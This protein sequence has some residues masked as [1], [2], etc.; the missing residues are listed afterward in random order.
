MALDGQIVTDKLVIRLL[1]G[2]NA[3]PERASSATGRRRARALPWQARRGRGRA[4]SNNLSG[5][6]SEVV[7]WK[8]EVIE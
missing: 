7:A 4:G 2:T 3:A 6:P 1:E 8:F 5:P